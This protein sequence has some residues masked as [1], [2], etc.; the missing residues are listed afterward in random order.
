MKLQK[1]DDVLLN[2]VVVFE[3]CKIKGVT[4]LCLQ[5]AEA[6][7]QLVI[8]VRRGKISALVLTHSIFSSLA[9]EGAMHE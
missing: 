7:K 6:V 5:A 9:A 1:L 8:R 2:L 4:L 3:A